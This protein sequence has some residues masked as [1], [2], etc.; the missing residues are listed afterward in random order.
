MSVFSKKELKSIQNK[1]LRKA[2]IN[3]PTAIDYDLIN[4]L[5]PKINWFCDKYFRQEVIGL[6]NIP[7]GKALLVGNH[8]SGI[9]FL[10][11]NSLIVDVALPKVEISFGAFFPK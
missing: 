2:D 7:K 3:D 11:L 10:E 8:N 9:S 1:I 6:S 4:L 5:T